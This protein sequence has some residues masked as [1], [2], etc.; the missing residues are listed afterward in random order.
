V[1]QLQA[2]IL[3]CGLSQVE[4]SKAVGVPEWRLSKAIH[5]RAKLSEDEFKKLILLAQ[6]KVT[7]RPVQRILRELCRS[8]KTQP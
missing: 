8:V 1:N 5:G 6:Q 3:L 7:G 4:I 2:L